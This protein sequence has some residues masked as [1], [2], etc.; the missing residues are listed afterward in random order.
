MGTLIADSGSTKTD[1]HL[2]NT[3]AGLRR[4]H[5]SGINPFFRSSES[6]YEE[7]KEKLLPAIGSSVEEIFFYGAGI[8]NSEKGDIIGEALI[9]LF[10]LAR[11]ETHSD[12]LAAAR[13]LFG[14]QPGIACI[15]G[16]G[17]NA[18][19]F[20][21]DKIVEGI[22]PLGFILGDESS[23]ADLG[24]KLVGDFFKRVM[25][26]ELR[27]LFEQQFRINQSDVLN[28]V[29]S[30]ERPNK[31]LSEF[32]PFL[33]QNIGEPYCQRLVSKSL[34]AFFERNV[35]KLTDASRYPIG[36]VGSVADS[37][38][39]LLQKVAENYG[40]EKPIILKDPIVGLKKYHSKI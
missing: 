24:K 6:I 36:F 33:S 7:L 27:S 31:Y 39:V 9:R 35:L 16:T 8:V 23:G 21:G 2:L 12:A 3:S 10:P 28:R 20:D 15:M 38:H 1:W 19:L 29:Y 17:S 13:A 18:C 26:F 4:F 11:I 25:P 30:Q 14:H 40:F 22:P 5:T 34:A 32:A 37:F